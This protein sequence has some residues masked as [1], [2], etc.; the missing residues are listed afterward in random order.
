M[1]IRDRY[2]NDNE[3]SDIVKY[4][5][6]RGADIE[7]CDL[8]DRTIIYIAC[9]R[10]DVDMV[11][12][13]MKCHVNVNMYN[14]IGYTPLHVACE[15]NNKR[16]VEILLTRSE[17]LNN[18]TDIRGYT[19][20]HIACQNDNIEIVKMLINNYAACGTNKIFDERMFRKE[21]PSKLFEEIKKIYIP[22]ELSLQI[23]DA[24]YYNQND[25]V[26]KLIKYGADVNTRGQ[27][28]DVSILHNACNVGNINIVTML[29][30]HEDID[31]N[32]V[33][34]HE[35][36]CPTPIFYAI[37]FGHINIIKLLLEHGADID[38]R[39]IQGNTVLHQAAMMGNIEIINLLI[40]NRAHIQAKCNDGLTALDYAAWNSDKDLMGVLLRAGALKSDK[41]H[42]DSD[43]LADNFPVDYKQDIIEL[44]ERYTR[45][46]DG[47]I[48]AM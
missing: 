5:I 8:M 13:L 18:T 33:Q 12:F 26:Q 34:T 21:C 39:N 48:N 22:K 46:K 44:Q 40:Q 32:I 43:L 4:L 24:V 47:G 10:Q 6:S 11:E 28:T 23:Y 30:N 15:R 16:I 27:Y 42:I 19:P 14:A 7:S 38:I 36:R 31:I 29:V 9:D 2:Y 1:C 41:C 45:K 25:K 17:L 20:L 35:K 37:K 3:H